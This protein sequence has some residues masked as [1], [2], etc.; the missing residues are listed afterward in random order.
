[1]LQL[2]GSSAAVSLLAALG[3]SSAADEVAVASR[4]TTEREAMDAIAAKKATD[5][6]AVAERVAM[7]KRAMDAAAEEKASTNTMEVEGPPWRCPVGVWL[8]P[9]LLLWQELKGLPYLAAQFPLPSID[10]V[11]LG[12]PGVKPHSEKAET[13]PPYMCLGCSNHTYNNNEINRCHVQ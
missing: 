3:T 12:S 7:D 4:A 5:D 10:S 13:K 1:V 9:L 11:A 6:A 8:S 2:L